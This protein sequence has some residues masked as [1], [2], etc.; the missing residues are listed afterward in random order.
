MD[1]ILVFGG[2]NTERVLLPYNPVSIGSKNSVKCEELYGGGGVNCAVRLLATNQLAIPILNIGDDRSGH[3]IQEYML[4]IA[5]SANTSEELIKYIQSTDFFAP[6][7]VTANSD[8]LVVNGVRT[9]FGSYVS[10]AVFTASIT[11]RIDT[12]EA[13][14]GSRYLL[15][16]IGHLPSPED[17]ILS[18]RD[19]TAVIMDRFFGRA[20]IILNPGKSQ[21]A[22]GYY[23][24]RDL[25]LK[26]DMLQMNINEARLF[27]GPAA[28]S[29]KLPDII[30]FIKSEGIPCTI[31]LDRFGAICIPVNINDNNVIIYAPEYIEDESM[32]ID[33]TGAG[34]AFLSG[35][36]TIL[37]KAKN[38]YNTNIIGTDIDALK[39]ALDEARKWAAFA[40]TKIGGASFPPNNAMLDQFLKRPCFEKV[41]PVTEYS[42]RSSEQF[43]RLV[44]K[45]CKPIPQTVLSTTS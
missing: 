41:Q 12:V 5:R 21:L 6:H 34:D 8:I 24:W 33:S 45:A 17:A 16:I 36:A 14:F 43:L 1:P 11:K 27:F 37:T 13:L 38:N 40:C 35:M 26:A 15:V 7:A 20:R 23:F 29:A 19:P 9:I 2:A 30:D 25:L 18:S 39:S 22:K 44:D 32:I 42:R 4:K 10:G 31:T 28:N 3:D